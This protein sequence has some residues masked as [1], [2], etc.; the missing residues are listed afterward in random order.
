[1]SHAAGPHPVSVLAPDLADR[2]RKRLASSP[3]LQ[4]LQPT[5]EELALDY[6]VLGLA[7]R[8]ELTNGSPTMHGGVLATLADTAVAFAL[9]TNF[10]GKMGFATTDLTIHFLRRAKTDVKARARILKKGRRVSVGE[11]D[12]VDAD[13]QAVARAL[14]SFLL[15]TSS[16]DYLPGGSR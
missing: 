2:L 11:V 10:D 12:V 15:T 14:T 13:G 3:A 7:Y 16:F 1:M 9:S 8:P 6:C 5:L 4:W